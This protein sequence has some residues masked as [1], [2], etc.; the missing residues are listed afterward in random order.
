VTFSGYYRRERP[1]RLNRS[2]L[3]SPSGVKKGQRHDN[4]IG[5]EGL[6]RFQRFNWEEYTE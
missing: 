3:I 1:I 5:A 2:R 6:H 4:Y